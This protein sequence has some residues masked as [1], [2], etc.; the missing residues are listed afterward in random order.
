[1]HYL[2]YIVV[3]PRVT[4]QDTCWWL[5]LR[6]PVMGDSFETRISDYNTRYLYVYYI[7]TTYYWCMS[8]HAHDGSILLEY[9]T[10]WPEV[11][12]NT[13]DAF[14]SS[15]T[16]LHCTWV[17]SPDARYIF[18]L[19]QI[20]M[21]SSFGG[22]LRFFCN[23]TWYSTMSDARRTSRSHISVYFTDDFEQIYL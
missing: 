23:A 12:V 16:M 21:K 5:C 22:S 18:P 19:P 3:T 6:D 10:R 20:L 15:T 11:L 13:Q 8:A 17:V 14:L 7:V 9:K 2:Y 1:M 4:A